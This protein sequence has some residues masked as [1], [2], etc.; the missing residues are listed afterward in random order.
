MTNNDKLRRIRYA[1]DISDREVS[2]LFALAGYEITP[3][4]LEALFKKEDEVGF[5]ECPDN[6][7]ALFLAGLIVSRRG[8]RDD[9][10]DDG[11]SRQAEK[12]VLSN[13]DIL[14]ALRI[15]LQLKD[16]DIVDIMRLAKVAVSKS[17]VS[18]LFRKRGHTNFR[19]CGDQFLRHFLAGLTQKY[20]LSK[21]P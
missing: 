19:P 2:N 14:K 10:A 5:D 12:V 8:Q 6:I 20:R 7:A 21:T 15:A 9:T 17:E 4:E 13:N 1:L 16:Q 3:I 18:A 11:N